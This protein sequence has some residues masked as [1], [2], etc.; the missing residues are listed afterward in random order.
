MA[1]MDICVEA[2]GLPIHLSTQSSVSQLRN[3]KTERRRIR[4]CRIMREVSM[5]EIKKCAVFL[6]AEIEALSTEQC[7]FLF[8]TLRIIK[9]HGASRC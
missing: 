3:V 4:T 9:P 8:R 2:P 7:V 1:L 6:D 5:D